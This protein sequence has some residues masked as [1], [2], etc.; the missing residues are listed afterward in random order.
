MITLQEAEAI[1]RAE[2]DRLEP[3]IGVP[4]AINSSATIELPKG[5]IFFYNSAVYLE[6]KQ[7][8]RQVI[9]QGPVAIFRADGQMVQY[10]SAARVETVR[11][12]LE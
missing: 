7:F 6:T 8:N 2:L 10:G 11:A 5:W 12:T 4:L 9:G 1:P 3:Q